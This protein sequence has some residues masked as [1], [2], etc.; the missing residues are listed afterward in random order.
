[1]SNQTKI[2]IVLSAVDKNLTTGLNRASVSVKGFFSKLTSMQSIMAGVATGAVAMF[3]KKAFDVASAL[4]D[5]SDKLGIS[6]KNLQEYQYAAAMS[7]VE[8]E[9]LTA[10]LT[11]FSRGIAQAYNGTGSLLK[12]L[13]AYGISVKNADLSMRS[14]DDVFA[15]YAD[16]IMRLKDPQ[17]KIRVSMAG[18]GK[19]GA[20]MIPMLSAGKQGL[21]D[22]AREAESLGLILD[23]DL[24]R[25]A[26]A[27]GDK[28]DT[29]GKVISTTLT[30]AVIELSPMISEVLDQMLGWVKA[31]R[32][33]I[34]QK[35]PEY[36]NK[37]ADAIGRI[38]GFLKNNEAVMEFGLV[39]LV[40]GGKRGML[41]G[42]V[43]GKTVDR[44]N[45]LKRAAALAKEGIIDFADGAKLTSDELSALEKKNIVTVKIQKPPKPKP[46]TDKA[47]QYQAGSID[48][49]VPADSGVV[50][51]IK[52]T[53]DSIVELT[54]KAQ[55]D[56]DSIGKSAYQKKIIEIESEAEKFR[57]A[58]ADK[59]KIATWVAAETKLAYQSEIDEL[60]KVE[61]AKLRS[62]S[63][64]RIL[65]LEKQKIA[66][67]MLPT[68][69]DRM[70][71]E[72]EIDRK[73]MSERVA[74]KRQELA[75]IKSD[76]EASH[77]DI[78][79]A[80]SDL[81]ELIVNNEISL[82]DRLR[83]I[84]SQ[85]MND[86]E[87]SWRKGITSVEEYQGAVRAALAAGAIDQQ[88]ADEKM[89]ASGND[90]GAA[91]S[92]GM[93]NARENMQTD[94]EMMIEIGEGIN[95]RIAGGIASV[96]SSFIEGGKESVNIM[97]SLQQTLQGILAWM[98]QLIL[99]QMILNALKSFGFGFSDGGTVEGL[100]DGG[101]VHGW[102]PSPTADNIPARLT[103]GEFVQPVRAVKFFGI[104]FMERIRR[105][106]FPRHIAH[107]LSG[108]TIPNIPS[109]QNLAAGGVAVAPAATTVKTGDTKLRVINVLDKNMVG[110]YL[111]TSDGETAI[112]NMIRRNG[113]SIKA[114]IA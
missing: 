34:N 45:D 97:Q 113:S 105:L 25:N 30:A 40:I 103:A 79:K 28:M 89:V 37:T 33:L 29:L 78:I 6:T 7:G 35:I 38:W 49:V 12:V 5:Q 15:D 48:T 90:M 107:A 44:V 22:Y 75:N 101:K 21:K 27:T 14:I 32:E 73:I 18:F 39:G 58:G 87:E 23:E 1:M 100:A 82:N 95:D 93:Q 71:A 56:I 41:V 36:M 94:A 99:K 65:A 96:W 24:L 81:A 8:N 104:E 52:S 86:M 64:D 83:G 69:L 62:E 76:T 51:K 74:L 55:N 17:E 106:K 80:E 72:L 61:D 88:T 85:R 77:A 20:D 26:E 43:V 68:E 114:L 98:A 91:L 67:S 2:E 110:D 10:S 54:R 111:R 66:A 42:A 3:I 109:G 59:V 53:N 4:V 47:P 50:N 112:I 19:A 92:L 46:T 57:A 13:D 70:S 84:S 16:L 11:K 108:G 63:Q 60:K 9:T 31:N 102:S